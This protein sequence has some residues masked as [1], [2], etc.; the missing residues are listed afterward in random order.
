MKS[1]AHRI[2]KKLV[3]DGKLKNVATC[4]NPVYMPDNG[5]YVRVT[6]NQ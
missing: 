3:E 2:L 6:E 1:T 5:Y 4:Q